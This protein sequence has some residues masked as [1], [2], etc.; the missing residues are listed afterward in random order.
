MASDIIDIAGEIHGETDKAYRFHDGV[1]TVW[2]PKNQCE[3][4]ADNKTMAMPEWL[5]QEKELI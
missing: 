5:A 1:R 3:W 2:L 4:D